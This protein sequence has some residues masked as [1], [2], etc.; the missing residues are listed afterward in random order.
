MSEKI[1]FVVHTDSY[2]GNFERQLC[3]Y[4][5]GIV[6]DCDVGSGLADEFLEEL[7]EDNF[8]IFEALI[9]QTADE[10]G[11][12]RPCSIYPTPG[13]LNNGNGKH[14]DA[15]EGE[16]GWPAYESVAIYLSELPSQEIIDMM[17]ARTLEYAKNH[18]KPDVLTIKG[19]ELVREMTTVTKV[20]QPI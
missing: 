17:K 9:E 13:R 7:G 14:H 11:V 2:S 1:I 10:N 5:T 3:A 4:V 18:H 20:A 8:D 16:T 12:C 6:G 19:F 15:A